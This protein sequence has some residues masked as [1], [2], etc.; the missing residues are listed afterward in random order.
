MSNCTFVL[1]LFVGKKCSNDPPCFPF[2]NEFSIE[3]KRRRDRGMRPEVFQRPRISAFS[4]LLRFGCNR[5]SIT[6]HSLKHFTVMYHSFT[7]YST[8]VCIK[9]LSD[10]RKRLGC[11]RS[12]TSTQCLR[13][14]LAWSR[15]KRSEF[16]LSLLF[17]IT[18][19]VSLLFLPSTRRLL[20]H[21]L[22]KN[23]DSMVRMPSSNE[24]EEF[25]NAFRTSHPLLSDIFSVADGSKLRL[26]QSR[27]SK[28]QDMF[29][30]GWTHDR[31]S[32]M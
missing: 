30:N 13:L 15:T 19:S 20:V 29:F 17:G 32:A 6:H 16:Y 2:K 12:M 3:G 11:P 28:I 9:V 10:R 7:P 8:N 5:S 25:K 26:E 18:G 1:L 31:Y 4:M 24:A 14:V 22:R 23:R 21:V 27:S